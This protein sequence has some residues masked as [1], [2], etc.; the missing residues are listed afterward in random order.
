MKRPYKPALEHKEVLKIIT[1]GDGRTLPQHFDPD[2]LNT[3]AKVSDN[4]RQIYE[5]NNAAGL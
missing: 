5:H 3:F 4:F 1:E 2:I